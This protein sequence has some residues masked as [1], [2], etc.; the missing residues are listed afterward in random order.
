MKRDPQ[1]PGRIETNATPR[2]CANLQPEASIELS[3]EEE[4]GATV[5]CA[6]EK[7]VVPGKSSEVSDLAEKVDAL[8]EEKL[9]LK[10]QLDKLSNMF[11][12]F[13]RNTPSKADITAAAAAVA[14][15]QLPRPEARQLNFAAPAVAA[16]TDAR[17]PSTASSTECPAKYLK[18][19]KMGMP[20]EHIKLKMERDGVDPGLLDEEQSGVGHASPASP[21]APRPPPP[22]PPL[23]LAV[24]VAAATTAQSPASSPQIKLS[25]LRAAA[26]K[27]NEKGKKAKAKKVKRKKP[28]SFV[29]QIKSRG[30]KKLN[31]ALVANKKALLADMGA[32][33]ECDIKVVVDEI[34]E[35]TAKFEAVVGL[36]G[37]RATGERRRRRRRR[38]KVHAIPRLMDTQHLS[39]SLSLSLSPHPP[40]THTQGLFLGCKPADSWDH[41]VSAIKKKR[42]KEEKGR[43]EEA[44]TH[45]T[46]SDAVLAAKS[47]KRLYVKSER[48]WL[49]WSTN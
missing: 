10:E 19:K 14:A 4:E 27:L 40:P 13:M 1:S 43:G 26:N 45:F 12:E 39:L 18:L 48:M 2:L 41:I 46:P 31:K 37:G 16:S 22:P 17:T 25:A 6:E 32:V 21:A 20:A 3:S 47:W 5:P 8:T 29:D 7:T 34:K 24:A 11:Q 49:K 44:S 35:W 42:T 33:L 36:A 23:G 9:Q 30:K 15:S 38:R 28:L